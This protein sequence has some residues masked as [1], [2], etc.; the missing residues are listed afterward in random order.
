MKTRLVVTKEDKSTVEFPITSA[1]Q[2]G[3]MMG[4]FAVVLRYPDGTEKPAGISDPA[5]S[6]KHAV[7]YIEEGKLFIKDLGSTNGTLVNNRLVPNC[8][9]GVESD[10]LEIKGD[11][12]IRIGNTEM[13][14]KVEV[15]TP[16]DVLREKEKLY[17]E[18]IKM[19]QERSNLE[20][21]LRQRHPSKDA[22]RVAKSF[23]VIL[24]IKDNYCNTQTRVKDLD[25]QLETLTKYLEGHQEFLK[26]I[27]SVRGRFRVRFTEESLREEDLLDL[28]N[29]CIR[30]AEM[31]SAK[32][33][34][35]G[36]S[37]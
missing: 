4:G 14:I 28:R 10:P 5:I 1:V 34:K 30:F 27:E 12:C 13:E 2:L 37:G 6:R 20:E 25:S 16:V 36:Q 11:A 23:R 33:M 35:E 9:H 15:P 32:F 18:L 19:S 26:E 29:F 3:K 31:W 21:A 7:I 8:R 17:E 24:D 22:E